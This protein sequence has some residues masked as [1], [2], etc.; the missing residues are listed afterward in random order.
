MGHSKN[1]S[2]REVYSNS[3]L[4][5]ETR[6][7][8]NNPTLD[9]KQLKKEQM[10][11]KVSTTEIINIRA[12]INGD[13]DNKRLTKLKVGSLKRQTWYETISWMVRVSLLVVSDSL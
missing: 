9:L 6:K 3:T 8:Q 5:Q 4:P 2:K 7:T 13:E 12:E 10:K 1:S 11:L